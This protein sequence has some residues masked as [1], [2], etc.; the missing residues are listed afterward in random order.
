MIRLVIL[1]FEASFDVAT[2]KQIKSWMVNKSLHWKVWHWPRLPVMHM[3]NMV[4]YIAMQIKWPQT[5]KTQ[6][7]KKKR[8]LLF[9][10]VL[11]VQYVQKNTT[12]TFKSNSFVPRK[13][14]FR[15]CKSI[16]L[17]PSLSTFLWILLFT[18]I[19]P[20]FRVTR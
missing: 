8:Y 13:D 5:K 7:Q 11:K 12:Y 10:S 16:L 18:W 14:C 2:F 1:S 19:W 20:K 6:K 3:W 4:V 15:H 9:G 17:I